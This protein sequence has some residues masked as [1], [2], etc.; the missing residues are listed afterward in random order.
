MSE[1]EE[2]LLIWDQAGERP[3]EVLQELGKYDR[4]LDYLDEGQIQLGQPLYR[5]TRRHQE[6]QRGDVLKYYY[7]TS[8]SSD[9]EIAERFVDGTINPVILIFS[10]TDV[11]RGIHNYMNTYDEG[12]VIFAPFNLLVTDRIEIG[13]YIYLTIIN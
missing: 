10:S 6:L 2:L 1:L 9:Q 3:Y 7:A 4:F 8:W 11:N 13:E 12:E 5:G